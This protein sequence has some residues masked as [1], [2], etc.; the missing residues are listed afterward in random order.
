MPDQP[1]DQDARSPAKAEYSKAR[2]YSLLILFCLAQF[3]DTFNISAL[4]PAIPTLAVALGMSTAEST[5]IMSAYSL[6]F[7]AF[8]LIRRVFVKYISFPVL[9]GEDPDRRMYIAEYAFIIGTASLGIISLGAGFLNSKIPLIV[10]RA[11]YGIAGSLTIPSALALIVAVFPEPLEQSRAIGAFGGCAA[12]GNVLGFI[13][14]G[15]FSQFASW[16]WVFWFVTLIS[17]PVAALCLLLIPDQPRRPIDDLPRWT[18]FKRLD[19]VGVAILTAALI[20]FIFAVISGSTNGWATVIVLVPLFISV[21]ML[22]CFFFYETRILIDRAAMYV[23]VQDYN[24]VYNGTPH[25]PT[26]CRPPHTWFYPNFSVVFGTSLLPFFWWA[27]ISLV[28]TNLWQGVYHRSPI[29]TAI[30]LIPS[31]VAAFFASFT[32]PL[33]RH[34]SPKWLILLGQLL[35]VAASLLLVF[36][37]GPDKYWTLDFPGFALGSAGAQLI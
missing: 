25:E 7:A 15:I 26:F 8:L 29:S 28:F 9:I 4:Y 14:G 24:V 1:G 16:H 3:V 36:A 12:I 30:H 34:I 11:L 33:S 17:L 18:R 31:S 10:L 13:I 20:L 19:I 22:V 21:A 6:T 27:V 37:D 32:G 35:I 2:R 5:W 23:Q